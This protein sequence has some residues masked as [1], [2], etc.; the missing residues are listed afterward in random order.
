MPMSDATASVVPEATAP[1]SA[2]GEARLAG[3][4]SLLVI[5][6][7]VAIR[8]SLEALLTMEGFRVSLAAD[9]VFGREQL[10][11]NEFDLLLLDLALPG[12]SGIELL[13]RILEMQ[14]N[15]PVIM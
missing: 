12:E 5:D 1:T 9:G 7:E 4:P 3:S 2:E 10:A 11:R 6:D 14:P 15:L 13:P 8:E